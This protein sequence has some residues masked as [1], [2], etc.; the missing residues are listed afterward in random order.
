MPQVEVGAEFNEDLLSKADL[1]AF[2]RA[3]VLVVELEGGS[4]VRVALAGSVMDETKVILVL[5]VEQ[6]S[7][8]ERGSSDYLRRSNRISPT[9]RGVIP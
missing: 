9:R 6:V 2:E 1:F 3:I 5:I 4:R 8:M 7:L